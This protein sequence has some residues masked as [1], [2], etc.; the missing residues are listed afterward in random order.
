MHL[1]KF[2]SFSLPF[3]QDILSLRVLKSLEQKWIKMCQHASH[4]DNRPPV[5]MWTNINSSDMNCY[6]YC[7]ETSPVDVQWGQSEPEAKSGFEHTGLCSPFWFPVPAQ[8]QWL[9]YASHVVVSD[10]AAKWQTNILQSYS[11]IMCI[12]LWYPVVLI[13]LYND[14]ETLC[15]INQ[16]RSLVFLQVPITH[17]S[18]S[19]AQ[20]SKVV[21]PPCVADFS[22][23][24]VLPSNYTDRN[25]SKFNF[26]NIKWLRLVALSSVHSFV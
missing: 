10:P 17:I 22:V 13:I 14:I 26:F 9:L 6:Q 21:L 16:T 18:S 25:S 23:Q 4:N 3:L 1:P 5:N 7:I 20:I 2:L 12:K 11:T 24:Y 19:W 8:V 15:P